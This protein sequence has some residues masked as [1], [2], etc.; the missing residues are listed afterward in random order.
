MSA[1][2]DT[3]WRDFL[4]RVEEGF[5]AEADAATARA[6]VAK[7][8]RRGHLDRRDDSN[9]T[10]LLMASEAGRL[11][12][13]EILLQ[14]G[15]DAG[16]RAR[17]GR[18]APAAYGLWCEPDDLSHEPKD[19]R[20]LFIAYGAGEVPAR[21]V[22]RYLDG[23]DL[24]NGQLR[25]RLLQY[26]RAAEEALAAAALPALEPEGDGGSRFRLWLLGAEVERAREIVTRQAVR[27]G[28]EDKIKFVGT[29]AGK[30]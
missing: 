3:F 24:P 17:S 30:R 10:P 29:A 15:A 5:F 4:L 14:A 23:A 6:L 19:A 18:T 13:C 8:A 9:R 2:A 11:D 27:M 20:R 21:H 22:V 12:I 25:T 16:A 7:L 1:S 26:S 28:Y